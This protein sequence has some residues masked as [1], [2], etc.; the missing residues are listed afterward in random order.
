[1][2]VG[3]ED[4]G[5]KNEALVVLASCDLDQVHVLGAFLA[6]EVS[7]GEGGEVGGRLDN[8]LFF[9]LLFGLDERKEGE[10]SGGG[11]KHTAIGVV[12]RGHWNPTSFSFVEVVDEDVGGVARKLRGTNG[13]REGA[14][15]RT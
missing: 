13:Y 6:D 10:V 14:G 2:A 7:V 12:R 5:V 15:E 1:M 11:L 8:Q 9:C 3:V 4:C